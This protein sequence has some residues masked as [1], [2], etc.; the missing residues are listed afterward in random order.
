MAARR[1]TALLLALLLATLVAT[2]AAAGER[3]LADQ[4]GR[5]IRVPDDPGR[6]VAMAPSITEIVF[7]LGREDRL[8][9][10]TLFSDYPEAAGDL[11]K[12]G[13][14]VHL[15]LERIVALGPDLCIA[16]KDGNPIEVVRRLEGLGIPVYAVDPRDLE[17][18]LRAI[19]RIGELLNAPDRAG[20][21]VRDMG[22][23][24][25]RVRRRAARAPRRPGVF[26]Q[27][28]IQPIVSVGTETFIHELIETAGG[29]NLTAGD[30]P[31]PRLSREQVLALA[32]E[33]I[34]ITS[35][36]RGRSF[37]KMKAE[38]ERWSDLPAVKG[39]RVHLIDSNLFD[40]PTPRMVEGLE[41]L[42]RLIHPGVAL[43][44]E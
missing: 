43:E 2:T 29:R 26:F 40:R 35:M 20:E 10:A 31:Y 21:L 9:G 34:L 18:V 27:I 42:F 37:E 11:P 22:R 19:G 7:A 5:I 28:G 24:I 30:V 4:A 38:W 3:R 44:G 13:S 36:A 12:V 32:P 39:G 41:V 25:D 1:E 15:D 17:T 8:V 16:V 6:V 23:R 14:Y 33:V